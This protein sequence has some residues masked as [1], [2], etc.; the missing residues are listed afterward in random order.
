MKRNSKG[1]PIF[2]GI[3]FLLLVFSIS[4]CGGLDTDPTTIT[5]PA[6]VESISILVLGQ[7][8]VEVYANYKGTYP[9]DCTVVFQTDEGW[10]GDAYEIVIMTKRP[11]DESKCNQGP[12]PFED[13]HAIPV[14]NLKAGEYIIDINDVQEGFE[15]VFD[16]IE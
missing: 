4:A 7:T 6:N 14:H 13:L 1:K 12:F 3:L 9:N 2:I 11:V 8:P 5:E 16:N 15:F 10:K